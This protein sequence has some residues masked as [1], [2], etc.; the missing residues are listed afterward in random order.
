M[1]HHRSRVLRMGCSSSTRLIPNPILIFS[2]DQMASDVE[3]K[4][5]MS[6]R[7]ILLFWRLTLRDSDQLSVRSTDHGVRVKP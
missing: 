4:I 1:D 2:R 7:P 6:T 5:T 3:S